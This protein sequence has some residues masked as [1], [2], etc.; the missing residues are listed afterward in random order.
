MAL[1]FALRSKPREDSADAV[2]YVL[3]PAQ[4]VK[5]LERLL[6]T[7]R[8]EKQWKA[9]VKK[10]PSYDFD[11]DEPERAYLPAGEED[12]E[13]LSLP[14]APLLLDFPHI[15][16]RVAAQRSRFVVFGMDPM[17][18]AKEAQKP[19]SFIKAVIVDGP[20]SYKI[21]CEL[22]ESGVTESVIFPDLDGLGREMKQLWEDRE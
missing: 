21:R 12:F 18:L 16:R 10:H 9:Y 8:A 4:I 6:E 11:E 2:A 7:K 17:W 1:H 19:N 5:Q 22:R 14:T 15:T 3:E 20:S 13:E